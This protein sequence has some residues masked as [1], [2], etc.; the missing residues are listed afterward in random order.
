MKGQSAFESSMD[1]FSIIKS[2]IDALNLDV[3]PKTLIAVTKYSPIEDLELAY[4]AGHRDFGESRIQDLKAKSEYF[5]KQGITDIR[6]HFIGRLQTNKVNMLLAVNGLRYVHSIDSHKLLDFIVQ[7]KDRFTGDKLDLFLQLNT[8]SEL[9]KGG[10]D[11]H[12]QLILG[13]KKILELNDDRF[14]F[15][16]LM[17]IGR[18]RTDDFEADAV[19]S[20]EELSTLKKTIE[21]EL[22]LSNLSLSMGMSQDYKL[23]LKY[24]SD[25]VRVGSAIFKT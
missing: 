15:R 22:K 16:G 25:F 5:E 14:N 24:G 23:A 20:F 12:E 3:E 2:N 4:K 8:S 10:F 6:W 1:R 18:I 11:N 19:K 13:A 21:L 17:T 7:R 9:E